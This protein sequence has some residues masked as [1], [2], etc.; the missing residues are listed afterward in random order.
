[1]TARTE[2]RIRSWGSREHAF[3]VL[4]LLGTGELHPISL[5][6]VVR[7]CRGGVRLIDGILRRRRES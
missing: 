3:A 5:H 4:G 2:R 7:I 6:G 1:M